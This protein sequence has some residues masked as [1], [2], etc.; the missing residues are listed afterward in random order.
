MT[1]TD[2]ALYRII[3][4]LWPILTVLSSIFL[5]AVLLYLRS[6]FVSH[7]RCG[8]LRDLTQDDLG[9]L[10]STMDADRKRH[11]EE[12]QIMSNKVTTLSTDLNNL[13]ARV[14][15]LP[16]TRTVHEIRIMLEAVRGAQ[17]KF[18]A[19]VDGIRAL[20]ARVERQLENVDT[21]LR[22]LS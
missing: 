11:H 17:S 12:I 15:E 21:Y 20:M 22:G 8:K 4:D 13:G 7:R 14:R 18:E 5:G 1:I 2:N 16:D 10:Q 6:R 9:R 19:E 3:V